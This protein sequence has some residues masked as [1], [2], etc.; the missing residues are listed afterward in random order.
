VGIRAGLDTEGRGKIFLPL[1]GIEPR[2]HGRPFRSQ[3]L[4][5]LSYPGSLNLLVFVIIYLGTFFSGIQNITLNKRLI[6]E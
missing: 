6:S 3:T 2:S 5:S 1:L 4:Y